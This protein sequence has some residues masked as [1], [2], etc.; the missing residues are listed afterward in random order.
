MESKMELL[1]FPWFVFWVAFSVIVGVFASERSK[2]LR[3]VRAC[4]SNL[5]GARVPACRSD[6]R[7][8]VQDQANADVSRRPV[9]HPDGV[10]AYFHRLAVIAGE[11]V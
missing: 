6:A 4:A 3:L 10:R 2:R 11:A 9:P 7:S 5:S 1:I 8:R